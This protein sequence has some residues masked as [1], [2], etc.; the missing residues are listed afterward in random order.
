ME[1]V[2]R[3]VFQREEYSPGRQIAALDIGERVV[4]ESTA[5]RAVKVGVLKNGD[6]R[7]RVAFDGSVDETD[8]SIRQART[9]RRCAT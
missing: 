1:A 6:C 2:Q 5:V 7:I 3:Q 9:D 4:G 8:W